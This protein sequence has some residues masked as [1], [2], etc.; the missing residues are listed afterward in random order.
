MAS[1]SV[2]KTML[3]SNFIS[4]SI[5]A[6]PPHDHRFGESLPRLIKCSTFQRFLTI[7]YD[8]F[9]ALRRVLKTAE[10]LHS[11]LPSDGMLSPRQK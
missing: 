1:P 10:W 7:F 2:E 4:S 11:R 3:Q 6:L 9:F 8:S 5:N